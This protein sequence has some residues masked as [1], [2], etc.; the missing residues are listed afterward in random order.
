LRI[1]AKGRQPT[2]PHVYKS[3]MSPIRRHTKKFCKMTRTVIWLPPESRSYSPCVRQDRDDSPARAR[4]AFVPTARSVRSYA[5]RHST[6][7]R[8]QTRF[9]H[10]DRENRIKRIC[11][12]GRQPTAPTSTNRV[13]HL[14]DDTPEK[15]TQKYAHR[16]LSTYTTDQI[17]RSQASLSRHAEPG[18]AAGRAG[19]GRAGPDRT[20]PG[21]R[22][23]PGRLAGRPRHKLSP[24]V[25]TTSYFA[26]FLNCLQ[27]DP[28]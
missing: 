26:V 15:S 13:C 14:Y 21:G 1:C 4:Q 11:A 17:P 27:T 10:F 3:G 8:D 6:S 12:T 25:G 9:T 7:C 18:R 19:P 22:T 28:P 20:V 23:K 24:D 16:H 2:A 5:L